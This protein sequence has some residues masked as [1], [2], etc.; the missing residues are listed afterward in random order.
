LQESV[1]GDF[2]TRIAEAFKKEHLSDK[3]EFLQNELK[4]L[5]IEPNGL[6]NEINDKDKGLHALAKSVKLVYF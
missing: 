6:Q 5:G 1:A 4:S 2:M 3:K